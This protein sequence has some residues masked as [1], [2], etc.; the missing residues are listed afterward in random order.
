M[1]YT[2]FFSFFLIRIRAVGD[3]GARGKSV[4]SL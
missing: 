2:F 3:Y 4:G 1:L